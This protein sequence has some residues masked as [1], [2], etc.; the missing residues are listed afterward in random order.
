MSSNIPQ[1]QVLQDIRQKRKHYQIDDFVLEF[2]I[3]WDFIHQQAPNLSL[4]DIKPFLESILDTITLPF[5]Q[6]FKSLSIIEKYD[7]QVWP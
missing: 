5:Y 7:W 6:K 3:L 2:L 4:T 1:S